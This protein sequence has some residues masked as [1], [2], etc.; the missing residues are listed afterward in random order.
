MS[1]EVLNRQD[2]RIAGS[3]VIVEE[4]T[5]PIPQRLRPIVIGTSTWLRDGELAI[6]TP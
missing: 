4:L 5:E 6:P 2:A 1:L 3:E